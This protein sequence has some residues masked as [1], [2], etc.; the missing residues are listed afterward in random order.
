LAM[1]QLTNRHLYQHLSGISQ[2]MNSVMELRS[3]TNSVST[4]SED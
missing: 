4:T 1:L 3:P 2:S